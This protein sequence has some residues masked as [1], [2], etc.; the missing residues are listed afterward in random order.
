LTTDIDAGRHRVMTKSADTPVRNSN[1]GRKPVSDAD[2]IKVWAKAAGRC[3]L[4]SAYL[5]DSA[6]FYYHTAL[7]GEVAHIV[8]ATSG[9]ASP[10]GSSTIGLDERAL[11]PNLLL[12]CHSCHR[13]VDSAGLAEFYTEETLKAHKLQHEHRVRSVTDFSTLT[14]SFVLRLGSSVRGR[15]AFASD[16]QV[17]EA[18]RMAALTHGTADSRDSIVDIELQDPEHWE[19]TWDRARHVIDERTEQAVRN[20]ATAGVDRISVFAIAPIPILV[21]LGFRLDDSSS[22]SVFSPSRRDDDSRWLWQPA[23]SIPAFDIFASG[24]Q[25]P[26]AT[27][28]VLTVGVTA[29]VRDDQLPAQLTG[30]PRVRLTP[31]AGFG[32][33]LLSSPE[34][35]D[36]FATSFRSAMA[37]IEQAFQSAGTVHLVAV[38]PAVAAVTI[39]RAYMS[40]AQPQMVIYQRSEDGFQAAITIS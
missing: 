35:V 1:I 34:A 16:R 21:Y 40:S 8:G 23:T 15:F 18:F 6:A 12:L 33:D 24:N 38:V 20:A 2:R 29:P 30:L 3:V 9:K 17:A 7:V 14:K 31:R 13:K 25:D 36:A 37:Q 22:V 28:V 39:G 27:E 26:E 32:P 10:R 19:T 5:I 4:C 11:E